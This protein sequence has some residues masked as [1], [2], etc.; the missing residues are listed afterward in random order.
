MLQS[1]RY[2]PNCND[3]Y[4]EG[5]PKDTHGNQAKVSQ[6]S[7]PGKQAD[8]FDFSGSSCL[9][10]VLHVNPEPLFRT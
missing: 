6:K 8:I 3:F 1:V 2:M 9:A 7:P 4:W 5:P 10:V